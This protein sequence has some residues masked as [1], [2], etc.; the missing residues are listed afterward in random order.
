MTGFRH[1][2]ISDFVPYLVMAMRRAG[3]NREARQHMASLRVSTSEWE[4]LD[5][6]WVGIVL[7]RLKFAA[8]SGD[9]DAFAEMVQRLPE[10]GWPFVGTEQLDFGLLRDDPLY[11]D[12]RDLP[13]VRAV[14]D[15]IRARLARERAEVLAF[16]RS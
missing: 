11:D 16:G 8:V 5:K 1:E 14:L 15:P 9:G 10:F 12:F 7:R 3:R 4:K 13:E 2:I 6:N